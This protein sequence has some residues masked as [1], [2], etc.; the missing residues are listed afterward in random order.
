MSGSHWYSK[1]GLPAYEVPYKDKKRAAAGEMRPTT[2]KDAREMDLLPSVTNI[3]NIQSKEGLVNW[4]IQWAITAALTAPPQNPE[5]TEADYVDRITKDAESIASEA[6]KFGQRVH[7]AI[8]DYLV[9][10]ETNPPDDVKP[11]FM[12][13]L[14]W[15]HDNLDISGAHFSERVVVGN[16]YAGRADLKIRAKI[17]SALY[18]MIQTAGHNPED[19]G[20]IDFKTRT[21]DTGKA[22]AKP[23]IYPQDPAQLSA[24][25]SADIA[26]ASE[27][28]SDDCSSWTAS[29]LINSKSA[30]VPIYPKVYT[31]AEIEK[32]MRL[33]NAC[34]NL[35]CIDKDY[36][37][38]I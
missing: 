12:N 13:W 11:F 20:T 32:G 22:S 23:N 24:Y 10:G 26:M 4:K 6:A 14:E 37:P 31:P 5:E 9:A 38:I 36:S 28:E 17:D 25:M 18:A 8:E 19:F 1:Q 34:Q 29:V 35:W 16:G 15:A 2:L 7:M 33:F 27:D 3:L 30:E 21:W